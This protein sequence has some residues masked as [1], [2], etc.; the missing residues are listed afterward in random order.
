MCW[1]G[2]GGGTVRSLVRHI[3]STS[4]K[5][6]DF[7]AIFGVLWKVCSCIKL[8][9]LPTVEKVTAPVF[10]IHLHWQNWCLAD[11]PGTFQT[12]GDTW[13]VWQQW[14]NYP[15]PVL[16]SPT[17]CCQACHQHSCVY[18]CVYVC[19]A[20]ID[21]GP[22]CC[23]FVALFPGSSPS[24]LRWQDLVMVPFGS[25]T[26]PLL[27]ISSSLLSPHL[28]PHSF[29][30]RLFPHHL[31]PPPH[32]LPPS[33]PSQ[34]LGRKRTASALQT[35]GQKLPAGSHG[36]SFSLTLSPLPC[37]VKGSVENCRA[38]L[39]SSTLSHSPN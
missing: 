15:L 4:K 3:I 9:T 21:Q 22:Q 23:S 27:S 11:T 13:I 5:M 32:L 33:A 39:F 36:N 28:L 19:R 29:T 10:C 26:P 12:K 35:Q 8:Y 20:E 31:L 6:C 1:W 14:S 18:M 16:F 30:P 24:P 25:S 37:S 17:H 34:A 2:S 7:F 38:P